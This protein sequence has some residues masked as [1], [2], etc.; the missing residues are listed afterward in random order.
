M[1]TETPQTL[2]EFTTRGK[3]RS[4]SQKDMTLF[5]IGV[6]FALHLAL[7][8]GTSYKYI[9]NHYVDPIGYQRQL[10]E[11][12]KAEE[13]AT[14]QKAAQEKPAATP[15]ATPGAKP[16]AKPDANATPGADSATTKPDPLH[17]NDKA[18]AP[19]NPDDLGIDISDTNKHS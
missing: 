14:T 6:S 18:P 2:E 11:E 17:L 9:Y 10:D 16:G 19:K 12:K 7:L 13:A 3:P 15:A 8:L 4:G 1:A 5:W